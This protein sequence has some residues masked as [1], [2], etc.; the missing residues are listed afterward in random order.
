LTGHGE[1]LAK[2]RKEFR[3]DFVLQLM[4]G[5]IRDTDILHHV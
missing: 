4:A 5:Y 2:L 1:E 3:E